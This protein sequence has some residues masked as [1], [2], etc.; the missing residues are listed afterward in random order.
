MRRTDSFEKTLILEKTEGRKRRGWQRMRWLDG[1]TDLMDMSLVK[2]WELVMNKEAWCAA[3]HGV[4]KSQT[5]L[6]DWTEL[7]VWN[8]R[9]S[10]YHM[11]QDTKWNQS[12]NLY[13]QDT[14][15]FAISHPFSLLALSLICWLED[16]PSTSIVEKPF[17]SYD[18]RWEAGLD[19]EETAPK[20]KMSFILG[21]STIFR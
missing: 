21:H 14:G 1:I 9:L 12:L 16:L 5:W 10:S 2:L 20:Y 4:A 3:V 13:Y 18:L 11:T 15:I 17:K 7:N 19:M 6:S 8:T